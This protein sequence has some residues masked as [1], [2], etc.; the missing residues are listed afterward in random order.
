MRSTH[1]ALTRLRDAHTPHGLRT[2]ATAL[3]FPTPTTVPTRTA[4]LLDAPHSARLI[5]RAT[6]THDG[7]AT[8]LLHHVPA[9]RWR[10]TITRTAATLDRTL[11]PRRWLLLA[12]TD[13]DTQVVV[14]T[15]LATPHTPHIA[16]P[17]T[18]DL[19]TAGGVGALGTP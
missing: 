15:W 18:V 14:A 12:T 4:T 9:D 1:D 19:A 2:L 5:E 7:T 3:G 6:H 16:G 11:D 17:A 10:A 8:L 13:D